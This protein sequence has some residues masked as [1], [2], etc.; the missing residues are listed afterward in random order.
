M[1]KQL[2]DWY[3]AY[4]RGERR[5]APAGVRGRV[6]EKR[7]GGGNPMATRA[8]LKAD[9]SLR[10]YRKEEN[11]WYKIDKTTGELKKE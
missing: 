5:I 2:L 4:R 11:A 8:K 9:L 1:L 3:R 7:E 10:V 6:Y